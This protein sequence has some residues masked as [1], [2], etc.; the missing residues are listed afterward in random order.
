M[1]DTQP[2]RFSETVARLM[3][4]YDQLAP[5]QIDAMIAPLPRKIVRWLGTNHPDN[6]LRKR[7]FRATGIRIGAGAVINANLQVSDSYLELVTIG[8]RASISPNVTIIA[9]AGPNNSLLKE[10]PYVKEHLV[11]AERVEI[12]NDA[13]IGTGAIL[14]PGVTV[15][16]GAIVGAGSVVSKSVLP[17][18]IVAGV[19]A[20]E[21]RSLRGDGEP[22]GGA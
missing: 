7:F 14:L 15:G 6:R 4:D 18:T 12:G 3:W 5:D 11:V 9:D 22:A 17:H 1:P 8:E 19:P 21:T 2:A 10:H 20:R 16:E 13:W